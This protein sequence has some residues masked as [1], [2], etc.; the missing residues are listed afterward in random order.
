MIYDKLPTDNAYTRVIYNCVNIKIETWDNFW[1]NIKNQ[2]NNLDQNFL[3]DNVNLAEY[4]QKDIDRYWEKLNGIIINAAD[5]ELSRKVLRLHN[6]FK[7]F[8]KKKLRPE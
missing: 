3:K 4:F 2:L 6:T 1:L 7:W 5:I 8:N